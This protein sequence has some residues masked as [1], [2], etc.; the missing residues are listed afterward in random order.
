MGTNFYLTTTGPWANGPMF[1]RKKNDTPP[2]TEKKTETQ[3]QTDQQMLNLTIAITDL[4]NEG[5]VF[6]VYTRKYTASNV[7]RL[8]YNTF[9]EKAINRKI[10]F[11]AEEQDI[12][13]LLIEKKGQLYKWS[14]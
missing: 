3:P 5:C 10:V 6:T 7:I 2:I 11:L 14:P 12:T 4:E 13:I 9:R 1:G 8:E